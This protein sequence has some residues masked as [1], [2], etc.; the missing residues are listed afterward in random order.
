MLNISSHRYGNPSTMS[1]R[2]TKHLNTS[3]DS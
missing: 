1:M 2:A 3:A